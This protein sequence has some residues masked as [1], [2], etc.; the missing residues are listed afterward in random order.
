MSKQTAAK[1]AR[2]KKRQSARDASWLPEDVHTDVQGIAR[3]ADEIVPRG[4]VFDSEYS[5]DEFISWY[6]PPSGIEAAEDDPREPVTRIWVSDPEQPQLVFVGTDADGAIYS[7]TVEQ[8]LASLERI[9]A[10]RVG[11]EQP[12]FG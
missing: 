6:Y 9:E 11:D 4:W 12:Q 2:R 3:I 10:Y 5:T 8:L 7:L 1:K